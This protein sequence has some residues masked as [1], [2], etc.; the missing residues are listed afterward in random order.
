MFSLLLSGRENICNIMIHWQT[1]SYMLNN[2]LANF[3][4]Y[5][6]SFRGWMTVGEGCIF[7]LAVINV[8][9]II[10]I[11]S[12]I[13]LACLAYPYL[14]ACFESTVILYC[15]FGKG[16]DLKWFGRGSA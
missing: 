3:N 1:C 8:L 5:I 16:T 7:L 6:S 2:C 11:M 13:C 15:I 12:V 14:L 9:L 10:S 4:G